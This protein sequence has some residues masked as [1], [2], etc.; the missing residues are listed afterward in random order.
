MKKDKGPTVLKSQQQERDAAQRE[1]TEK[2]RDWVMSD[3]FREGA[4][5]TFEKYDASKT[6]TL[7][8]DE[9][10][11]AVE[12]FMNEGGVDRLA[13]LGIDEENVL[14]NALR[15]DDNGDGKVQCDELLVFLQC[16]CI[17]KVTG[18]YQKH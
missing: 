16:L 1:I 14:E 2:E 7:D 4:V 9:L 6:G 18:F 12:F 5:Y 10:F 13:I 11:K 3:E 17:K 8:G 15:Y